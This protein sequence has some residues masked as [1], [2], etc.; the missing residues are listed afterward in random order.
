MVRALLRQAWILML[1]QSDWSLFMRRGQSIASF[2]LERGRNGT[3][4]GFSTNRY[5]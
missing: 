3:I 2:D 1:L 5:I 4:I